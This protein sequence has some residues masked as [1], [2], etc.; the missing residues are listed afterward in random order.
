MLAVLQNFLFLL[1]PIAVFIKINAFLYIFSFILILEIFDQKLNLQ[2]IFKDFFKLIIKN[3]KQI[4]IILFSNSLI[5]SFFYFT[6]KV[7]LEK[8]YLTSFLY[9]KILFINLIF[10][11]LFIMSNRMNFQKLS[12]KIFKYLFIGFLVGQTFIFMDAKTNFQLTKINFL[13]MNLSINFYVAL[14]IFFTLLFIQNKKKDIALMSIISGAFMSV[15]AFFSLKA[16]VAAI[17]VTATNFVAIFL[18]L[19][20]KNL[21]KILYFYLVLMIIFFGIYLTKLTLKKTEINFFDNLLTWMIVVVHYGFFLQQFYKKIKT[22]AIEISELQ[23]LGIILLI[24]SSV[25]FLRFSS[26]SNF[27][28]LS[29]SCNIGFFILLYMNKTNIEDFTSQYIKI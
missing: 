27:S 29:I 24:A 16:S 25:I 28:I 6:K 22:N 3:L 2:L 15:I 9:L 12:S 17:I 13:E 8:I 26:F 23:Q 10:L 21:R 19:K 14:S 4:F 18:Y 5:I 1:L 11:F 20:F 7:G